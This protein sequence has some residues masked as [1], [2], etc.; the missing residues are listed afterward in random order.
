M[1]WCNLIRALVLA[2]P[3]IFVCLFVSLPLQPTVVVFPH[4]GSGF[5]L[6]V[7]EVSRLHTDAPQS[8]GLLCTSDQSVSETSA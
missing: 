2:L 4:P 7:F 1:Y 5:S 3:Y 6:L 8:V